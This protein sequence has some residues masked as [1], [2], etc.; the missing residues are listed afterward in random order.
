MQM[1]TNAFGWEVCGELLGWNG[2]QMA[3]HFGFA[4]LGPKYTRRKSLNVEYL[5][6]SRHRSLWNS[7]S[8]NYIYG[9][10]DAHDG[11]LL[12]MTELFLIV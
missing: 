8:A 2:P 9:K 10:S 4:S 7:D 6:W 12:A 5:L 1:I 11:V 3:L